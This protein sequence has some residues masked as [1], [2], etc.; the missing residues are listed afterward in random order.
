MAKFDVD[1]KVLYNDLVVVELPDDATRDE[2]IAA[3]MQKYEEDGSSN[4]EYGE[5][6]FSDDTWTISK[7][8]MVGIEGYIPPVKSVEN[9]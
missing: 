6:V 8:G 3:A 2:I 1:V 7:Q 9:A 4:T 5:H